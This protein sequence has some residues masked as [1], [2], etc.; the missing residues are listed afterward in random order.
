MFRKAYKKSL[1]IVAIAVLLCLSG[2]TG[3]AFLD[4]L[5]GSLIPATPFDSRLAS[6]GAFSYGQ[7]LFPGQIH[8]SDELFV[9]AR[10]IR[11][12][13]D[14]TGVD[15]WQSPDE[16]QARW[17]GDC[18]DKAI[19]LFAELKKNGYSD[20]RLVVGRFRSIDRGLHVWVTLADDQNHV[21]VLD[22]T[23][24]R[25]IWTAADFGKEYYRA[26]YSFDG[27]YRYRHD[28]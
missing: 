3:Q 1:G 22:P 16:T 7:S 20:V 21:F 25:K 17:A 12:Q 19:W 14:P 13:A 11:Y 8:S 2:T 18:E 24:Q 6:A 10:S 4:V 23:E 15:R 5:G 9:T 27:T 28:E 26:L